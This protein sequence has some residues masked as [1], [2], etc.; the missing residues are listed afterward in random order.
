M[1]GRGP[2]TELETITSRHV[3]GSNL[4]AMCELQS[5]ILDATLQLSENQ[6]EM[7]DT[8]RAWLKETQAVKTSIDGMRGDLQSCLPGKIRML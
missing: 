5:K 4:C 1:H 2:W 8:M 6:G 7:V 3:I